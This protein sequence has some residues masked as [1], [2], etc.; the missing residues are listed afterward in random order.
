MFEWIDRITRDGVSWSEAFLIAIVL[1]LAVSMLKFV[2]R[3]T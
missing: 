2:M 1:F 3:N